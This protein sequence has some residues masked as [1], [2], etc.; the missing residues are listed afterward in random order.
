M[1]LSNELSQ[2][3]NLLTEAYNNQNQQNDD[4]ARITCLMRAAEILLFDTGVGLSFTSGA[5]FGSSDDEAVAEF[6][7]SFLQLHV[8]PSPA[9]RSF[10]CYFIEM[11]SVTRPSH[12]SCLCLPPLITI[13]DTLSSSSSS[14]SLSSSSGYDYKTGMF[15]LR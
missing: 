6:L 7:D 1:S 3:V 9:A 15:A 4:R 14:S 13:L 8:D 10:V 5:G 2:I 12:Y 11:L